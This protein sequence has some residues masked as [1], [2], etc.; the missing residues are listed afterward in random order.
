MRPFLVSESLG[1]E[2][3][4]AVFARTRAD[5]GNGFVRVFGYFREDGDQAITAIEQAVRANAA[6]A[7]VL[8]AHKLKGEAREFGARALAELA[9][10]I[11]F[12][13]RDCIEWRIAPTDLVEHVV[14]LRPLFEA[15]VEAIDMASNPLMQRRGTTALGRAA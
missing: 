4:W 10:H 1:T 9:E 5:L 14:N 8:P 11:E 13:A 2:I 6:T 15:T 7:L 12:Q 3:D